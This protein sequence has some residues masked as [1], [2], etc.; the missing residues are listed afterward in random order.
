MQER[1]CRIGAVSADQLGIE[2]H[3]RA[4]VYCSVQPRPLA[5]DFDSGLVNRDSVNSSVNRYATQR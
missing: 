1:G 5:G 3:F 4:G 2:N